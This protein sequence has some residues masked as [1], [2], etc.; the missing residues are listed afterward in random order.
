MKCKF[1]H[2]SDLHLGYQQYNHKER[3]ND[4]GHAFLYIVDQ[5]VSEQVDFVI[6]GGDLFQKRAID[7]PTLIQAVEGLGRLKEAGIPVAADEGNHERAHYRDVFSW[8]DFLADRGYLSLLNPTSFKEGVPALTP[9]E[10][11]D[12]AYLDLT[13]SR[14]PTGGH[15]RIYGLK[16]YGA[17]TP[18]VVEGLIKALADMDHSDIEYVVLV[19]HAGLEGVLPRYSATLTYSQ[20]APLYDYVNYLALG[21]IHKPFERESWIYNPGS[22][23]TCGMDEVA[24]PDRGYDLVE[25]DTEHPDG[26]RQA[27]KHKARLI[28]NP[29]RPFLRLSFSVETCEN[30][31]AL[32]TAV[33]EFARSQ[34]AEA[35]GHTGGAQPVVEM[36]LEGVLPFDRRELDMKRLE[37]IVQSTFDPLLVRVTNRTVPTEYEVSGDE[38][39]SRAELERKVLEDLVERDARY[40]PAAAEW[41]DL[42]L[43][44]K[45]MVLEDTSPEGIVEYLQSA[46]VS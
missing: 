45:R 6:L 40:R 33:E 31:E 16:Y 3:F 43:N 41:A 2:V 34:S 30:P 7:P 24:W 44:V 22:P 35:A 12:G 13:P 15:V 10:G 39:K 20:V 42:I 8:M 19:M 37:V 4:F 38:A 1:L 25:V 11:T 26:A 27:V 17:S 21:H 18:R 23:E 9:W 36:A 46:K 14:D 32:Y 28:R 5:A 29:R